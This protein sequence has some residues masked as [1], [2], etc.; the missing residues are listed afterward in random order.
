MDRRR[1]GSAGECRPRDRWLADLQQQA[2]ADV[3]VL[4]ALAVGVAEGPSGPALCDAS[5]RRAEFA[6]AIRGRQAVLAGALVAASWQSPSI[7]H[8]RC[9]QAGPAEGRVIAHRDDYAR[10]RHPAGV[11]YE[12]RARRDAVAGVQRAPHQLRHVRRRRRARASGARG[13]AAARRAAGSVDLPRDARPRA[14]RV[15]GCALRGGA[16]GRSARRGDRA[17]APR[18]RLRRC[19]CHRGWGRCPRYRAA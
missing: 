13:R 10:D 19:R 2:V 12:R 15:S 9:S 7:R 17:P 3:C 11:A 16:S 18:L 4:E 5:A 1:P 8:A 14:A 6:Y